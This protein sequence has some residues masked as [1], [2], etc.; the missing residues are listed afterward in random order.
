M[1]GKQSTF[2][3]LSVVRILATA[4]LAAAQCV[5][6]VR[7]L[8]ALQNM[9]AG[10]FPQPLTGALGGYNN[11]GGSYG[12]EELTYIFNGG[13]TIVTPLAAN[14]AYWYFQFEPRQCW[15]AT[16]Y[17]SF[18]FDYTSPAG[19]TFDMTLTVHTAACLTNN[20]SA[21]ASSCP[22]S[23]DSTYV[24]IRSAT[25]TTVG[26]TNHAVVPFAL[27]NPSSFGNGSID[28][29]YIKDFTFINFSV[30]NQPYTF[31][32]FIVKAGCF[33]SPTGTS[34]T[35]T[36]TATVSAT[37]SAVP[38]PSPDIGLIAG[39]SSAA[40]ILI[41]AIIGGILIVRKRRQTA[42]HQQVPSH[43]KTVQITSEIPPAQQKSLTSPS[44]EE[45]T[46]E[47]M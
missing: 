33:V 47:I 45:N 26:S 31:N 23:A 41:S 4:S 22:R 35:V 5:P 37:R 7:D 28:W 30:L 8:V 1:V 12:G 40:I 19:A 10:G 24:N 32:N 13:A 21:N 17:N 39:L 16:G 25:I 43:E 36:G 2:K 11:A 44:N 14:F 34:K 15:D 20:C 27:F 6:A 46:V 42:Y 18:E 3:T 9:P 29:R 38:S